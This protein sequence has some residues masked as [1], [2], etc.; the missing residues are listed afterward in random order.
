MD[1]QLNILIPAV[2][3]AGAAITG[4][5]RQNIHISL[6]ENHDIVTEADVL[7][8]HI[9]QSRLQAA[10]PDDGWLSEESIDDIT[11]LQKRRVWVVDPIDGTREFIAGIPEYAVSVALVEQGK[12]ILACVFN[13]ETNELFSAAFGAGTCLNGVPVTCRLHCGNKLLLLASRSESQRS[14]WERFSGHDIK[15]VGSIAYKLALV[16]AGFADATF[17][18]GQ[19]NEWDIAAGVLLV[20]EALGHATDKNDQTIIFNQPQVCVNGIIATS[21]V[22]KHHVTDI[23]AG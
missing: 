14:E 18:L 10:F 20:Q 22:A 7:A 5:R 9:L 21:L 1:K 2:R 11:R 12:P 23:V 15:I 4:L 3:E 6:K 17:S 19:K 8:N 16:A 13:P